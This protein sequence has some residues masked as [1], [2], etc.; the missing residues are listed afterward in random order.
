MGVGSTANSLSFSMSSA[1]SASVKTGPGGNST[2]WGSDA[3]ENDWEKVLDAM[4]PQRDP[5]K[6]RLPDR[7]EVLLLSPSAWRRMSARR[8]INSTSMGFLGL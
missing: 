2:A 7:D 6:A 5:N 1:G 4:E 8:V 3:T